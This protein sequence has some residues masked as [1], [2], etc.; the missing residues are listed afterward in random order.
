MTPMTTMSALTPMTTPQIAM[1]V[2]ND[3]RREPPCPRRYRQ[4]MPSSSLVLKGTPALT[5][6]LASPGRSRRAGYS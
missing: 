3:R 4:A 2:M 6:G 1:M 5:H